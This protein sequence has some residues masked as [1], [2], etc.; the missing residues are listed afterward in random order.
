[1]WNLAVGSVTSSAAQ[2][3]SGVAAVVHN[4]QSVA[5]CVSPASGSLNDATMW[6]SKGLMIAPA[7]GSVI[8]GAKGGELLGVRR[9]SSVSTCKHTRLTLVRRRKYWQSMG[10]LA[11]VGQAAGVS[12]ERSLIRRRKTTMAAQRKPGRSTPQSLEGRRRGSEKSV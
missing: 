5:T 2:S 9:S 3:I 11:V 12:V 7:A 6:T 4:S 10:F 8:V 1:M